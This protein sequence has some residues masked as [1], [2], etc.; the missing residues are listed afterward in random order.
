MKMMIVFVPLQSFFS[1]I[2]VNFL[3]GIMNIL[4]LNNPSIVLGGVRWRNRV[5]IW[6]RIWW[7]L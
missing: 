5:I 1:A 2:I 7:R 3:L 6:N 4:L